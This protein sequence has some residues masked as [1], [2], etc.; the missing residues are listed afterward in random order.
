MDYAVFRSGSKQ[1]K[2]VPGAVI[3]VDRL[4]AETGSYVELGDVL[5]VSRQGDVLIGDPLVPNASVIA[6]VES[7]G[8]DDKIIVFKY[9]RKVRY[10]RKKGHRQQYTRLMVTSIML[11]DEEIG[12]QDVAETEEVVAEVFVDG[13]TGEDEPETLE[14]D[15]EELLSEDEGEDALEAEESDEDGD[16]DEAEESER[17]AS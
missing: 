10:R 2:A 6:Q 14:D 17:E 13:D 15:T 16:L 3:D 5:A 8:Q 4:Q 9:K 12:I 7:H 1:Y 11:G